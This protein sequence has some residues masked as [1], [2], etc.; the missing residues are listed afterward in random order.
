MEIERDLLIKEDAYSDNKIEVK[1][2]Y[3]IKIEK[4]DHTLMGPLQFMV[5]NSYGIEKKVEISTY[6]KDHPSKDFVNFRVQFEN[7]DD[8]SPENIICG[9]IRG[10]ENL[11][12]VC[13]K[14]IEEVN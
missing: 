13:K 7:E 11:Q 14:I 8:Q 10:C 9:V 5:N 6:T 3:Q 1:S 2:K 4:E 12:E